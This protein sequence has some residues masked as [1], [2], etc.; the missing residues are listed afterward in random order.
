MQ[1]AV[2]EEGAGRVWLAYCSGGGRGTLTP[3]TGEGGRGGI[4]FF[5]RLLL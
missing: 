5:K 3:C 2:A 4:D 1:V